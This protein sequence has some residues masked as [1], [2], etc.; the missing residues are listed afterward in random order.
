M[1]ERRIYMTVSDMDRLGRM[2]LDAISD[3]PDLEPLR[4]LEQE[5]DRAEGVRPVDIPPDVITM[6][7]K[8]R[9]TDLDSGTQRVVTLVY[10][11]DAN[12]GDSVSILSPLGTALLGYRVGNEIRWN[13]PSGSLHLRIDELL[14]QP[15][16]AG[17]FSQ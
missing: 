1:A 5:L 10:P 11:Q 4:A 6:N 15:E 2:V 16:A 8:L 12:Q 7:S 9:L 17:D 3:M 14:Y 13:T